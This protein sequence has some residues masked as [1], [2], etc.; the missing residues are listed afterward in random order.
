M[1]VPV[2]KLKVGCFTC[3]MASGHG[4]SES[5]VDWDMVE[6]DKE[7]RSLEVLSFNVTEG[8]IREVQTIPDLRDIRVGG[9]PL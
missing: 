8:I 3:L 5:T 1:F 7:V 6:V 4:Q 2:L 9:I